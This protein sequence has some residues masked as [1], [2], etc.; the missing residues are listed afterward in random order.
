MVV[1]GLMETLSPAL[2]PPLLL[3]RE[4]GGLADLDD[5]ENG[6]LDSPDGHESY[7]CHKPY[8]HNLE[9]PINTFYYVD[10][11]TD[12]LSTSQGDSYSTVIGVDYVIWVLQAPLSSMWVYRQVLDGFYLHS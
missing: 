9:V 7:K 3:R 10:W 11:G 12:I 6:D 2:H 5:G 4:L 8:V 1:L